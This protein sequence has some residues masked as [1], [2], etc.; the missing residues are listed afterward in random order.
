MFSLQFNVH[1]LYIFFI[2]EKL[3]SNSTKQD[4]QS[5]LH[6]G[7]TLCRPR[8]C[9]MGQTRSNEDEVARLN[10]VVMGEHRPPYFVFARRG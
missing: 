9:G 1:H 4:V 2:K 5:I 6:E 3:L 10:G 8:L 7:G